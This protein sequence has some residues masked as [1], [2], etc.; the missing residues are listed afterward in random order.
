MTGEPVVTT[1]VHVDWSDPCHRADRALP[2]V[3]GDGPTRDRDDRG[4]PCHQS[5]AEQALAAEIT[6]TKDG[7]VAD[8]R[9]HPAGT[10]N[11]SSQ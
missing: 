7:R 1:T 11:G 10:R 9:F 4:E 3:M 5:C 2:C 8:E 6:Q